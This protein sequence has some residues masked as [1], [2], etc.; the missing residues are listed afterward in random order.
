[1]NNP[2]RRRRAGC[3][4]KRGQALVE[5][6]LVAPVFFL[7]VFAIIDFGRY[8]YYVQVLNNAARE[9][10]RYAIVHGSESF[11][12]SGPSP[13]DPAVASVVRN[14]AV[15]VVGTSA[16]LAIHSSWSDPTRPLDPPSNNRGHVVKVSV[17]Y[18]FRSVIPVVP[19]PPISITGV[20]CLVVNH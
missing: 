9:G 14:S 11:Q 12:P 19:F 20:S 2:S 18:A 16:T 7:I 8:V 6:A 4:T 17:T 13:D 10:A 15:G 5:F 3:P 1:M